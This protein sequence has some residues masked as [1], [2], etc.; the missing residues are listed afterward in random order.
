MKKILVVLCAF[1]SCILLG[2][3][4]FGNQE[5]T[6]SSHGISVTMNKGFVEKSIM[7]QTAYFQG[8]DALFTALKEDFDTLALIDLGSKS[9][10]KDYAEAV[11]KNNKADYKVIE[12]DDL[13]YF[14][15]EK[16]I[17]GKDYYYL[18]SVYKTDDAFWLVNFACEKANKEKYESIFKR[19]AKTVKFD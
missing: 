3:C 2:G 10:K 18:A 13:T 4:A 8:T 1:V 11:V 7:S 15:Y 19:W 12:K 5:K 16:S 6:Y 17:S 9:T 14:E